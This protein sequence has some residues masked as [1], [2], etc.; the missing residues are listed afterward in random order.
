MGIWEFDI[1]VFT[2]FYLA[3]G[4]LRAFVAG[5]YLYRTVIRPA[6]GRLKNSE[7]GFRRFLLSPESEADANIERWVGLFVG[8]RRK[9]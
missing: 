5:R 6:K 7:I 2:F 3:F 9:A 4:Y 1:F 8:H